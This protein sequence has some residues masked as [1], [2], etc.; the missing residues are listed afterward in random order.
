VG[1]ALAIYPGYLGSFG[2]LGFLVPIAALIF[3][4]VRRSSI[5]GFSKKRRENS[6][7]QKQ[8]ASSTNNNLNEVDATRLAA[9]YVKPVTP[10]LAQTHRHRP[11][12]TLLTIAFALIL[13]GLSVVPRLPVW[14]SNAGSSASTD[15]SSDSMAPSPDSAVSDP[16]VPEPLDPEPLD[17]EPPI[18]NTS[19]EFLCTD[20]TP[21]APAP[22]TA[23]METYEAVIISADTQP[24]STQACTEVTY[25]RSGSECCGL[26]AKDEALGAWSS[27]LGGRSGWNFSPDPAMIA[28]WRTHFYARYIP[29]GS[30]IAVSETDGVMTS[31][32]FD[33]DIIT[34]FFSASIEEMTYD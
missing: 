9:S 31:V 26:L 6:L 29:E 33:G 14:L 20:P 30:L 22:T 15:S 25:I 11:L 3:A 10:Y 21:T 19:S 4:F 16:V 23:Q 34:G 8:A 13:V 17:P 12:I 27:W 32:I 24:M 5:V 1:T 28:D 2:I 18:L 7:L